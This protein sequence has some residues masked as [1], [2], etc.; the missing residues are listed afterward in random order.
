MRGQDDICI[1]KSNYYIF[2]RVANELNKRKKYP[3]DFRSWDR[4]LDN[5]VRTVKYIGFYLLKFYTFTTLIAI[6]NN[7]Q[8]YID[9]W[10]SGFDYTKRQQIDSTVIKYK[11]ENVT[12]YPNEEGKTRS[13]F[14]S[15]TKCEL[16]IIGDT[17]IWRP[18]PPWRMSLDGYM[19]LYKNNYVNV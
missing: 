11:L 13:K 15:D 16:F 2:H 12:V 3:L 4:G 14:Y 19:D 18:L 10:F 9:K 1:S 8:K 7:T 17:S 6:K 5:E